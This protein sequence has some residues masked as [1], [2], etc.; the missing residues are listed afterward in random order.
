MDDGFSVID[1]YETTHNEW[2]SVDG[3]R[4]TQWKHYSEPDYWDYVLVRKWVPT[5]PVV[6][7]K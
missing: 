5:D 4:T 3:W 6:T 1:S 2:A 7:V